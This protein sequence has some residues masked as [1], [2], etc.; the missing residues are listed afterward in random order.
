VVL[1]FGFEPKN[2]S[3][4]ANGGLLSCERGKRRDLHPLISSEHQGHNLAA[5]YV[6]FAYS[7]AAENRTLS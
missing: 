6:A 5:H 7:P 4:G 1:T 2:H 3:L